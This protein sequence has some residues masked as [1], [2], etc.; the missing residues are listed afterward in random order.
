MSMHGQ[1]PLPD[2]PTPVAAPVAA[3]VVAPKQHQPASLLEA[4]TSGS[5][6]TLLFPPDSQS[7]SRRAHKLE[8]SCWPSLR[9]D[10]CWLLRANLAGAHPCVQPQIHVYVQ[11]QL[12]P[13]PSRTWSWSPSRSWSRWSNACPSGYFGSYNTLVPVGARRC[14]CLRRLRCLCELVRGRACVAVPVGARAFGACVL[15]NLRVCAPWRSE[16]SWARVLVTVAVYKWKL[17]RAKKN[18]AAV[19]SHQYVAP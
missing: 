2:I 12:W 3:P 14:R 11:T 5:L 8:S 19:L 4:Q 9:P 18:K 10:F 1:M 17:P 16:C 6:C 15:V 7:S 13:L